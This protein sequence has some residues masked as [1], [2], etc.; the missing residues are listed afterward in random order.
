MRTRY[1][2]NNSGDGSDNRTV[3]ELSD[4]SSLFRRPR[5]DCIPLLLYFKLDPS[6]LQPTSQV[7]YD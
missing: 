5:E 3:L 4:C 1:A 7:C 2:C 6:A